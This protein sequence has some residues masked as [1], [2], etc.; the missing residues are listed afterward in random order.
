LITVRHAFSHFRMDLHAYWVRINSGR[1][2]ALGCADHA[3]TPLNEIVR[4]A[5][6]VADRKI[7]QRLLM[8]NAWPEF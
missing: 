8:E 2:K 3:W 7:L 5:L 1:P 6:P 4:Y